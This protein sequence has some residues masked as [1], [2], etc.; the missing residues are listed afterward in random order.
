[1]PGLEIPPNYSFFDLAAH[2]NQADQLNHLKSIKVEL[3]PGDCVYIPAFWWFQIQTVTPR[4]PRASASKEEKL[5]FKQKV[6]ELSVSADFWYEV[7]SFWLEHVFYGIEN[8]F[9]S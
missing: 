4:K 6:K 8:Q 2:Q 5:K 3:Q 1:M 9:L 7:H